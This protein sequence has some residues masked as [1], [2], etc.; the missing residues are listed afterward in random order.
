MALG[1][2]TEKRFFDELEAMDRKEREAYQTKRLKEVVERAYRN[3][4]A[5][6]ELF[7]K[8]GIRPED[9]GGPRDMERL[10]IIRKTDVIELQKRYPPYGGLLT[11]E[12][13][14]VQRVFVTP[15]PIYLPH[16]I[17]EISWFGKTFF[18]AGFKL[19]D[20]VINTPTYHMSPAG[21]LFHEGVR[22]CGATVV[23]T[24]VGNTDAQIRIMLDLKVTAFSGMPSF[25]MT[26]IKRAEELGYDFKKDFRLRKAW[27]TGEMLPP[28]MRR[29]F[30]EEYGI[31]TYQCY[32]VTEL[33]GC[34]AY[35]CSEKSGMHFMDEYFIEIVD[36]ETGRWVK[37][38]EIGELVATPLHNPTWGLIRFG[39]GDMTSFITAPC[40]CG[41]TSFRM[42][43]V[44]GRSEDAVKVRG[45]FIVKKQVD[46]FFSSFPQIHRFQLCVGRREERDNLMLRLEL[47]DESIDKEELKRRIEQEFPATCRVKIDAFEFL[48][49]GSILEEKTILDQRRWE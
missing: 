1:G 6:R 8:N 7:D 44:V 9:I 13:E 45:M 15:G 46:A 28:S 41:R 18:A 22:A 19:G 2:A 27:F 25:L 36:P 30:E 42:T 10:P 26:I 3:A 14:R 23:P 20:V 21:M 35:E 38:G 40:P 47:V 11:I 4:R 17:E 34:V 24:G 33:G 29:T 12:E 32:S 31:D 48:P 49:K 16:Q 39:T 5:I 37:E 43:G